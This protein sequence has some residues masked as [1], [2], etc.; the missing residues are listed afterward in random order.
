MFMIS[1]N[2]LKITLLK[3]LFATS[4]TFISWVFRIR[5]DFDIK[6]NPLM[7]QKTKLSPRKRSGILNNNQTVFSGH[8][9]IIDKLN[10]YYFP[11][12]FL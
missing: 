9:M 6:L 2:I 5:K 10:P 11:L 3:S 7:L 8:F 4:I 12:R 1:F